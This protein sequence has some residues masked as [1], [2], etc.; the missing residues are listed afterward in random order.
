M[1]DDA[2]LVERCLRGDT[3]AFDTLVERYRDRVFSLAFRLLGEAGAA[4]DAMQEAFLRAYTRLPLYDPAQPFSTWLLCLTARVCLNARRDRATEWRYLEQ[5][6]KAMPPA[7]TLEERLYEREQRRTL[8]RLLM[9]L[10]APQRAAML[11]YYY[12]ELPIGEVARALEVPE[13]TVKTW[14]YRG[15]ESL[16]RWLEEER[17]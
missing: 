2:A 1:Q 6:A 3:G 16:R 15:R 8:Q 7:P 11:L 4:E 14:L 5:A 9:R 13:G 17:G 10:P 12:E